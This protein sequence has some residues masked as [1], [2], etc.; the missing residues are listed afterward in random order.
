VIDIILSLPLLLMAIGLAVACGTSIQGCA[1][2]LIKPGV[3]LVI[4]IITLFGW[5]Y[6]A[7]IVRGQTL[8]LKER[9]FVEASRATGFGSWHIMTREILPNMMASII[10]VATLLIP[11][12][13]LFEAALSYLSVGIPPGTPSWG[14]MINSSVSDY[15]YVV[16]WW[17]LVF[18]AAFLVI[19]T[20]AFN[21]LGDGLRDALDPRGNR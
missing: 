15:L 9:E 8:S 13:I 11:Q 2:G 18:P 14:G 10:V 21:L 20:L 6:V 1:G 16:S 7:R 4:F 3:S 5:P 12:N 17:T 19:T